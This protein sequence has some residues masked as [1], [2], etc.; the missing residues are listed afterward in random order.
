[1]FERQDKGKEKMHIPEQMRT[2]E[3]NHLGHFVFCPK[4]LGFDVYDMH[5]VKVI[6][7]GLQSSMFNIAYGAPQDP[8]ISQC[9][10]DI[11]QTFKGQPFAWWVPPSQHNPDVT[12][13]LLENGLIV[14]A[15]EQAMIYTVSGDTRLAQ[16]T[17]L[18]IKPA[19]DQTV[20]QDFIRVLDPYDPVAQ[21][22]YQRMSRDLL[23]S[24]EKLFVGYDGDKPVTIGILFIS[25]KCAG[26]FSLI[27]SD[28]MRGKGYGTD[29]MR[30]LM[31]TAQ[32]HSCQFITL[33]ASSD[34]GYRIYER[35]G[36]RRVGA[37]ECFEY[38]GD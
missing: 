21:K 34:S 19:I 11:K 12:K 32:E 2:I 30:V 29:M 16:K 18:S 25:S 22:F 33:S 28:A 15:M 26:I 35:L 8:R 3:K 6:N 24:Q 38:K 7:C 4:K 14:E 13:G 10:Q 36:F 31:K 5:G 17:H 9:I 27:T 37:F 1:M 20:L 23:Q